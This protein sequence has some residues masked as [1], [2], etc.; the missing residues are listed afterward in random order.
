M[1]SIAAKYQATDINMK[2]SIKVNI[3]ENDVFF[4]SLEKSE[5]NCCPLI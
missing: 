5:L 1:V 2:I 3:S 4:T